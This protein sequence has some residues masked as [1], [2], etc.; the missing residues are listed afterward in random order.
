M[1]NLDGLEATRL[2]RE[3]ESALAV[4][5][6]RSTSRI[7]IIALTAHAMKGDKEK[8]LEAGMDDYTTKPIKRES[9]YEIIDKWIFS[10][11]KS[12]HLGGLAGD[13]VTERDEPLNH[14]TS[15]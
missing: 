3:K 7:P 13:V 4:D 11:E 15:A 12:I 1:P 2:I 5:N 8:C 14:Q 9:V 10:K 6:L